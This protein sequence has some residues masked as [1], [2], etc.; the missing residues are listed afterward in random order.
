M[1]QRLPSLDSYI[2]CIRNDPTLLSKQFDVVV[3]AS[4]RRC[5]E[6]HLVRDCLRRKYEDPW[7]LHYDMPF[8]WETSAEYQQRV[9]TVT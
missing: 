8:P 2:A 5:E 7:L 9:L 1:A 6:W 3:L 4:Q